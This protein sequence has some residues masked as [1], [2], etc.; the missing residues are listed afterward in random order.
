MPLRRLKPVAAFWALI[1]LVSCTF[2]GFRI[3]LARVPSLSPRLTQSVPQIKLG[4]VQQYTYVLPVGIGNQLFNLVFDTGSSDLWV[5]SHNCTNEDCR[6]VSLYD[7]SPT[8]VGTGLPFRLDYL[9][10]Q[11]SGQLIFDTVDLGPYS[12]QSQ[13]LAIAD[14]TADLGLESTSTSGILGMGLMGS[15]SIPDTAGQPFPVNLVSPFPE[16]E[17]YFAFHLSRQ[18]GSDD[19]QASFTVSSIDTDLVSDPSRITVFPVIQTGRQYDYW[20]LCI[21]HFTINGQPLSISSSRVPG[22]PCPMAVLDTG[23]TLFLGPSADVDAIYRS[24]NISVRKDPD[25]GYQIP[26]TFAVLIGV[27]LGN[28][29]QEYII[30]PADMAWNGGSDDEWC[31]GG[32]QAN[33]N[34]N[35]G[36]WLLGDVFL[37][38]AYVV[39]Y[40]RPPRIGLV[41]LTD[42]VASMKA[43][44]AERGPA[45]DG[46]AD[47]DVMESEEEDAWNSTT[48]YVKRWQHRAS[49][50]TA[51]MFGVFAGGAGFVMGGLSVVGWRAWRGV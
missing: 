30:D 43:F 14:R 28:P 40:M 20:K 48:A 4:N 35:S 6:A 47:S 18:S 8:S 3:P 27:V 11:V 5:A 23:T 34:V 17:Q 38:N 22:A 39:H 32:I 12:I 9:T 13:I 46:E 7:L 29:A 31:T 49:S 50:E 33:D 21:L 2:S 41:G 16:D 15:A 37:R 42:P 51:L 45:P 24:L 1:P 25:V 19:P 10:G 36:D 44:R 26:C